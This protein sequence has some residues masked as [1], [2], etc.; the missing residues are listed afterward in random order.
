[1]NLEQKLAQ[2]EAL[3]AEVRKEM[4]AA[5]AP[6]PWPQIG[7][8]YWAV[9]STGRVTAEKWANT[10]VDQDRL[11]IGNIFRTEA[12]AEREVKAHKLLAELRR[13]PGRKA[14]VYGDINWGI[15]VQEG[16]V[17][18][19]WHMIANGSWQSIGFSAE[20]H[21]LAA[22]EAVGEDNI[23]AAAEWLSRGEE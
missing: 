2:A 12:D 11:S 20:Q 3:V 13:Q 18:A 10:A 4:A 14:F 16:S 1:M 23:R 5:Q 22:V 8:M 15:S 21:V 9:I 17:T 19:T 7:D 6:K